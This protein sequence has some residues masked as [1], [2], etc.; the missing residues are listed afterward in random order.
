MQITRSI[1]R[2]HAAI[3]VL[4][5]AGCIVVS[6]LA[7]TRIVVPAVD[8]L[9]NGAAE[10]YDALF[11]AITVQGGKASIKEQQP[12]FVDIGTKDIALVIDTR[13]GGHKSGLSYL[14]TAQAGAVLTRDSLIIKNQHKIRVMP[15]KGLPDFTLNSG[16]IRHLVERYHPLLTRWIWIAIVCYFCLSKSVQLLFFAMIPYFGARSYSLDLSYGQ[17][18]KV[19]AFAMA[20]PVLLDLGLGAGSLGITGSFVIYFAVYVGVL[21]FSV[22]DLVK[23]SP[24]ASL[25]TGGIHPS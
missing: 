25:P 2:S 12:Y 9:L 23:S 24:E 16:E 18:L 11:P 5:L 4:V 1:A 8:T 13:E 6:S 17:A 21:I 20:P 22:W 19:A 10:K 3:S 14:K 15:L 7:L